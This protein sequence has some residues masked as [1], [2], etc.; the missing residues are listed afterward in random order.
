MHRLSRKFALGLSLLF[1]AANLCLA[2]PTMDDV[3]RKLE[4]PYF[5][6]LYANTYESLTR[7][8]EADGFFQESLTG[9]YE[10]MY[11]RTVGALVSLFM[12]TG[13]LDW[14]E[15]HLDCVLKAVEANGMERIPHVFDR[16]GTVEILVAGSD[17]IVQPDAQIPLYRLNSGF[18]GAQRFR[19]PE[20]P[21][22]AAVALLA[23]PGAEG[24]AT[25]RVRKSR[26]AEPVRVV[27]VGTK[28]LPQG[29]RW[30]RFAFDPPLALPKGETYL[31]EI[32]YSGKGTAL[33][34][35]LPSA[36][37]NPLAG[38][39]AHDP[40]PNE[41]WIDHPDHVTAFALDTGTLG[42]T[43]ESRV[44]PILSD[45]DQIDGQAHI[46]MGWA[47]LALKRGPTPFEDRTWPLIATLMDRSTDWPYI[48]RGGWQIDLGLVR[49]VSLEHSR[50]GRMWDA[51][52][53]LTQHFMGA[54]LEDMIRVADR[55][56]D[57]KRAKL[58]R[59]RLAAL[60]VAVGKSLTREHNGKRIYLEMRLPD[61]AGGKPY[62]GMGWINL[63]PVAAQWEA[64]DR[65]VL[66]D[67]VAALREVDLS[68][69]H[70]HKWL[71]TDWYP[72]SGPTPQVIGKGVGWEIDYSR[73]ENEPWRIL[74]WL[75]FIEAV[76]EG[77]L[78]LESAGYNAE[79]DR[80]HLADPGNGEQATWWCWAMARLRKHVGLPAEPVV[81]PNPAP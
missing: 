41:R 80:W 8:V 3:R 54:A 24:T 49:N 16:S 18:S 62:T 6:T 75:D 19:A 32:E 26:D 72:E 40:A 10:G 14:C 31:L 4:S 23:V 33:W 5:Q 79:T 20:R 63:S 36:A 39:M 71:A 74:E 38:A 15:L 21:V 45:R 28:A 69:W 25:A 12:E 59:D 53:L 22:R 55:R 17:E 61:S 57:T 51:W 29:Q 2:E 66:R 47:R 65:Q 11:P 52:D 48:Q 7:R 56:G 60:R 64:L 78:Y 42:F 67:T 77:P 68:D 35:G 37:G 34:M 81:A 76:N 58:W 50:E 44:Y 70:G 46:L 43:E 73:Q 9:A 13:H 30:T 1:G 27:T